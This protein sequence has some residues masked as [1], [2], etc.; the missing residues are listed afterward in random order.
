MDLPQLRFDVPCCTTLVDGNRK[1]Q[2]ISANEIKHTLLDRNTVLDVLGF[3]SWC[4]SYYYLFIEKFSSY[5]NATVN[6]KYENM[7]PYELHGLHI[8]IEF[9]N[10][11]VALFKVYK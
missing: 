5:K 6:G 4:E 1:F 3:L 10:G 8:D 11:E 2:N 9:C 7:T